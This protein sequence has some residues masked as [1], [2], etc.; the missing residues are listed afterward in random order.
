MI[1][2]EASLLTHY[3]AV[4]FCPDQEPS[5][6]SGVF[7]IRTG[8]TLDVLLKKTL[9]SCVLPGSHYN[10]RFTVKKSK[11]QTGDNNRQVAC[12]YI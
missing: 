12:H 11:L 5:I 8:Y 6:R 10:Q 2:S 1:L 3:L 9:G 4:L 7:Y